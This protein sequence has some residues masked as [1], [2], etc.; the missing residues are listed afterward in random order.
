MRAGYKYM[1]LWLICLCKY[2]ETSVKTH[3]KFLH[4]KEWRYKCAV[5]INCIVEK[6]KSGVMR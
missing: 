2:G 3:V 5:T 1:L 4:N 6:Y